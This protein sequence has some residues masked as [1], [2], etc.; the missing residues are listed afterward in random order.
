MKNA[1]KN[2]LRVHQNVIFGFMY[3]KLVK[4]TLISHVMKNTL[5]M[6]QNTIFSNVYKKVTNISPIQTVI[7]IVTDAPKHHF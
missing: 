3:K 4:S 5:C 7:K 2:A 6:H 1:L